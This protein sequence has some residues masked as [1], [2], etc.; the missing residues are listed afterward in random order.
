MSR[1]LGKI[2]RECLRV[3]ESYESAGTRPTTFSVTAEVY[4]V[5]RDRHGNRM[6]SDAQH[7][8][9]KRALANLRRRDLVVGQRDMGLCQRLADGSYSGRA[10]RCCLWSIA[11]G[12]GQ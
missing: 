1:G 8:A 3:I 5:E 10:E 7:T 2:Q 4:Q 9:I 6:I 11:R 12:S